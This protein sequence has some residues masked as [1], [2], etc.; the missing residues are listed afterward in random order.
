VE[1]ARRP[2]PSPHRHGSCVPSTSASSYRHHC[3]PD[4]GAW[5][6]RLQMLVGV[7]VRWWF[8]W[9][10]WRGE[11]RSFV[12]KFSSHMSI[13]NNMWLLDLE[14]E[15]VP[16]LKPPLHLPTTNIV[17]Y[18][19][20]RWLCGKVNYLYS[21]CSHGKLVLPC[22]PFGSVVNCYCRSGSLQMSAIT[23]ASH[24][25]PRCGDNTRHR[26]NRDRLLKRHRR[27]RQVLG[28]GIGCRASNKGTFF[29]FFYYL[30]F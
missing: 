22:W 13:N 16:H 5:R 14:T 20:G 1:W 2:I 9:K 21:A 10:L 3:H 28:R 25:E 23:I 8:K 29:F 11:Y 4:G 24:V 27:Q 18:H 15:S 26:C 17:T 6:W 30:I 12:S 7:G 19:A